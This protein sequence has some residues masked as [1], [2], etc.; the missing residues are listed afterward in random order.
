MRCQL[1]APSTVGAVLRLERVDATAGLSDGSL[2]P[3]GSSS[4]LMAAG[5]EIL[6]RRQSRQD[7]STP[8]EPVAGEQLSIYVEAEPSSPVAASA[9]DTRAL[10]AG[11]GAGER[12][13]GANGGANADVAAMATPETLSY[14]SLSELER[15]GY[16]YYLERVLGLSEDRAAARTSAGHDGLEARARGTLIHRLMETLDFARS[17]PLSPE[18]VGAAASE[19]GMRVGEGERA[20]IARLIAAAGSAE[21]AAAW[22]RRRACAASTRSRSLPAPQTPLITGVIDL[23]AS[24]ADGDSARPRLQERPDRR[25]SRPGGAGRARVRRSSACS[26]RWRSCAAAAR[27]SRSST[28]SWNARGEWVSARYTAR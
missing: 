2:E 20:E 22:Q 11:A 19:L 26:T 23:L 5:A 1:N 28:G 9:A 12:W 4:R 10:Q 21:L 15:C 7:L 14:T 3:V 6:P 18:E 27:A 17:R 24:E 8:A 25:R 16:R 13:N